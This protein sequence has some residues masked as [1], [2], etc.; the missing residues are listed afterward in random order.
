MQHRNT[1]PEPT[2]PLEE[3]SQERFL[4]GWRQIVGEPPA[5]MLESRRE[6]IALLV[7]SAPVAEDGLHRAGG[8]SE[9]ARLRER[10]ASLVGAADR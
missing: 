5:V 4:W 2:A 3:L 8:E 9:N 1:A 10:D 6:M 7:E